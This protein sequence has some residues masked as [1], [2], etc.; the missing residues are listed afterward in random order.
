MIR[1]LDS[2][3]RA[4]GSGDAQ[5]IH[6]PAELAAHLAVGMLAKSGLARKKSEPKAIPARSTLKRAAERISASSK[7]GDV[8]ISIARRLVRRFI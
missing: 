1:D 8:A 2:L 4:S 6:I 5:Q 3:K 7:A